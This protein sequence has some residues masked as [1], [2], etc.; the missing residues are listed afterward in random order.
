[1]ALVPFTG[2]AASS[3]AL[4][5]PSQQKRSATAALKRGKS[6]AKL[7]P[8]STEAA[9]REL[10]E[11]I[12]NELTEE[13]SHILPCF[14]FL[15]KRK[16]SCQGDED[17][18]LSSA[19]KWDCPSMSKLPDHFKIEFI[20]SRSHITSAHC[21]ELLKND[22][23]ALDYLIHFAVQIPCRVKFPKVCQYQEVVDRFL[24]QRYLDAGERLEDLRPDNGIKNGSINWL[25][26]G[27]YILQWNEQGILC[28]LKHAS[29]DTIQVDTEN[30]LTKK[31]MLTDNFCDWSAALVKQGMPPVKLAGFFERS[32]TGPFKMLNYVGKPKELEQHLTTVFR[33]WEDEARKSMQRSGPSKDIVDGLQAHKDAI[34]KQAMEKARSMAKKALETKRAKH[35]VDLSSA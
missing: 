23:L 12:V 17:D 11:Q 4:V 18:I 20:C 16:R 28:G 8:D 25:E 35:A 33:E 27:C 10:L 9:Q 3:G 13:P 5:L 31:Y 22:S 7:A 24:K 1:M 6:S 30:H 34:S 2:S 21:M 26:I 19:P 29:G 32:R 14:T 15:Q